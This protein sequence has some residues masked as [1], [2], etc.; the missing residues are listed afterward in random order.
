MQKEEE[1]E[2][3]HLNP[4]SQRRRSDARRNHALELLETEAKGMNRN[5]RAGLSRE[6]KHIRSLR[7]SS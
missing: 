5:I 6:D 4:K 7:D 2:R 1:I 3:K